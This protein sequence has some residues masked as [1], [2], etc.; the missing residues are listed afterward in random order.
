LSLS[1]NS[2][3]PCKAPNPH[4][5]TSLPL[6]DHDTRLRA[7]V[8]KSDSEDKSTPTKGEDVTIKSKPPQCADEWPTAIKKPNEAKAVSAEGFKKILEGRERNGQT[9]YVT[10]LLAGE[11]FAPAASR[12]ADTATERA[13][14]YSR[15]M[16]LALE[17]EKNGASVL[18][19]QNM[20]GRDNNNS[21]TDVDT[22]NNLSELSA[23]RLDLLGPLGSFYD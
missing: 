2:I 9:D 18:S 8:P 23:L 11:H 15:I 21:S 4:K 5:H 3:S 22:P 16:A 1:Q 13:N 19:S 10:L 20:N 7:P 6:G 17:K 12:C 14:M